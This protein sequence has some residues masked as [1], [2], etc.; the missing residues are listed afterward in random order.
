M[1]EDTMISQS[2]LSLLESINHYLL[3]EEDS[4]ISDILSPLDFGPNS[5]WSSIFCFVENSM[6]KKIFNVDEMNLVSDDHKAEEK[7]T[8]VTSENHSPTPETWRHYRGVRRRPWGKFAA[9]IRD[10][11][12]K[13]VRTWLGTYENPED[14]ALAY[15]RAAFKIRGSR[16]ILN[17]PHLIGS[18]SSSSDDKEPIRV[19]L[20]E[21]LSSSSSCSNNNSSSKRRRKKLD[22]LSSTLSSSDNGSFKRMKKST[23]VGPDVSTSG[24][25]PEAENHQIWFDCW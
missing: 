14:A 17:F 25:V 8:V 11:A 4:E 12:K 23:A 24:S 20:P 6:E 1:F 9:E 19:T 21:T 22:A 2:D 13:G 3:H 16:A 18:L 5:T 7:E 15:D 10:P